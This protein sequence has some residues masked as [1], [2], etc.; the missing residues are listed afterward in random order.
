MNFISKFYNEMIFLWKD[1]DDFFKKKAKEKKNWKELLLIAGLPIVIIFFGISV[2]ATILVISQIITSG[3]ISTEPL[4]IF[5]SGIGFFIGLVFYILIIHGIM[6][7]FG[8]KTELFRTVQAVLYGTVF[9]LVIPIFVAILL[10][11][12]GLVLTALLCIILGPSMGGKI[13][14]LLSPIAVSVIWI[15][16]IVGSLGGWGITLVGLKEHHKIGLLKAAALSISGGLISTGISTLILFG[17]TIL[18][19]L[20]LNLAGVNLVLP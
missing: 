5:F 16:V 9:G 11:V 17:F 6:K 3:S 18:L 19:I 7:L 1:R 10:L 14:L 15:S 4:R 2:L 12:F 20:V 8:S 13:G